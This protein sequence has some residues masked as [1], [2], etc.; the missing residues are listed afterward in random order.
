[1]NINLVAITELTKM[2]FNITTYNFSG[3]PWTTTEMTNMPDGID[4]FVSLKTG[5]RYCLKLLLCV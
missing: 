3:C 2:R 5:K 1:M 4:E